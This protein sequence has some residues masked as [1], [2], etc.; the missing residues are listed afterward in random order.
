MTTKKLLVIVTTEIFILIIAS[1]MGISYAVG[2]TQTTTFAYNGGFGPTICDIN[3]LF[4]WDNNAWQVNE[5]HQVGFTVSV[6]NINPDVTDLTI[7]ISQII[8]RLVYQ[9]T[10]GPSNTFSKSVDLLSQ[11][12]SNQITEL[13]DISSGIQT[14]GQSRSF[15]YTVNSGE[16]PFLSSGESRSSSVDLI[17]LIA[18][19]GSF[20]EQSSSFHGSGGIG[21][22][23]YLSNS[24]QIAGGTENPVWIMMSQPS[25]QN[26]LLEIVVGA[27]AVIVGVGVGVLFV[28][29]RKG[30]KQVSSIPQT[31]RI[32][33]FI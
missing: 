28:V 6:S 3:V 13:I 2:G 17:Y 5:N 24:G 30:K 18:L 31:I 33:G 32:K 20:N 25:G 7:S 14:F 11:D 23:G 16:I 4:S 1:F 9:I 8:V 29:R 22:N 12:T 10:N 19:S 26:L 27:A 15:S 21:G